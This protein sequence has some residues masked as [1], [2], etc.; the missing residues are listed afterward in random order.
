MRRDLVDCTLACG[1]PDGGS[2][3]DGNRLQFIPSRIC[4]VNM[5]PIA[6]DR[7]YREDWW[8]KISYENGR[9][10]PLVGHL[11]ELNS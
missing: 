10:A 11:E 1:N 4:P 9:H 6:C 7:C 2:S 3:V 8:M 5:S